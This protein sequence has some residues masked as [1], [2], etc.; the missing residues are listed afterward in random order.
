MPTPTLN[1]ADI[2]ARL[3]A[4]PGW[5]RDG[6]RITKTYKLDAYLAGLAFAAAIGTLAEA[7]DH[8]PELVIGW[9]RVTVSYSTHDA[10]GKITEKDMR[11]A[12]SIEALGYPRPKV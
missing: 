7:Q 5:E 9:K 12:A 6:D 2:A 1:D 10:G 8:H 3:T 11:A 4:L